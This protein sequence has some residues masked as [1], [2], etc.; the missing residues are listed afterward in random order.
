MDYEQFLEHYTPELQLIDAIDRLGNYCPNAA[1]T[2]DHWV[3]QTSNEKIDA[4][5]L[6]MDPTPPSSFPDT[7]SL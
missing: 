4:E 7:Q 1:V 6:Q 2:I 3:S 5:S